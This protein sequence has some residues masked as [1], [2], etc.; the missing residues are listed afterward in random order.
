MS[1]RAI[2]LNRGFDIKLKG[3][4]DPF[5]LDAPQPKLFA[6]KPTDLHGISPIPK[7]HVAVGEEVKAGDPVFFDKPSPRIQ[8]CSPVS[9]EIVEVR[10]GAKRAITEVVILADSSID[11]RTYGKADPSSLSR[12]AVVE[13]MLESGAWVLM[14]Q[15]PF[16]V[17]PDPDVVPRDIYISAFDTAPL[18]P[19]YDF[20]MAGQEAAFQAGVLALGKLTDGGVHIGVTPT[21]ADLFR[22]ADGAHVTAFDGPHPAGNVGVHIHHTKPINKGEV[23]W[24]MKPQDVAVLGRLFTEGI[25]DA[26]RTVAVTGDE[27]PP[28]HERA[29]AVEGSAAHA[30]VDD[31]D[32]DSGA[33]AL[34][35]GAL[36]VDLV[37]VPLEER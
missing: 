32:R 37:E 15:R 4:A 3:T 36:G 10:R 28:W 1:D 9:G 5:Y 29:D 34:G 17:V 7:L 6:L 12:D 22:H 33:G 30:G 2:D 26:Q 14:R 13:R 20:V 18:A 19:N 21:S 11:Y 27:V 16:N 31:G 24:V 8:Y 23:V 35:P 25:F